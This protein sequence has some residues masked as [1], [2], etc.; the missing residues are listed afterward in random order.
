MITTKSAITFDVGRVVIDIDRED[1]KLLGEIVAGLP[2]VP[3]EKED[4]KVLLGQI[5]PPGTN[6][7]AKRA[8][9]KLAVIS[10]EMTYLTRE[11]YAVLHKLLS[12]F[13]GVLV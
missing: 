10:E 1:A 8:G 3:N 13:D 11:Q 6:A 5:D 2:D 4:L 9:A 12:Q 7:R